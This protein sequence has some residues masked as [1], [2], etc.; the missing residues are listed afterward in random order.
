VP[1]KTLEEIK[2]SLADE[3]RSFRRRWLA[4]EESNR[5]KTQSRS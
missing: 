1:F 2:G 4:G 3:G 5:N